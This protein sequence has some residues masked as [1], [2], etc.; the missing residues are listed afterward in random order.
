VSERAGHALGRV[1]KGRIVRTDARRV[2]WNRWR[3]AGRA[4]KVG[5]IVL[6][7]PVT[8]LDILA[9]QIVAIVAGDDWQEDDLFVMCR[10]AWPYRE[11]LA[12]QF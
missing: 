7:M 11:T 4:T 10:R 5:S 1:P 9:Q 8:P 2:S 3:S 6:K 12:G